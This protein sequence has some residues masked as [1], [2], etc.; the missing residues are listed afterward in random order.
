MFFRLGLPHAFG[1]AAGGV[2]GAWPAGP[3]V[4]KRDFFTGPEASARLA[5]CWKRRAAFRSLIEGRYLDPT[6]TMPWER[7]GHR[8][9]NRPGRPA[10]PGPS[11][12]STG[13]TPPP[14]L[15]TLSGVRE[16]DAPRRLGI[17]NH[18]MTMETQTTPKQRV[19]TGATEMRKDGEVV[20][21]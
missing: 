19:Y 12:L 13:W 9:Q 20:G 6:P 21:Y 14:V 15:G 8:N 5:F 18:A 2:R 7:P 3:D 10:I 11:G 17:L 16:P 1:F 4:M